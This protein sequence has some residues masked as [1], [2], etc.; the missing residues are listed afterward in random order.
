M[1]QELSPQAKDLLTQKKIK[2][3][4]IVWEILEHDGYDEMGPKSNLWDLFIMDPDSKSPQLVQHFHR[5]YWFDGQDN[6]PYLWE[7]E[8]TRDAILHL[9]NIQPMKQEK[10]L[11]GNKQ[12]HEKSIL[13]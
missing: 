9:G 12:N 6:E 11:I 10:N 5:E 8:T 1:K 13:F 2:D 3:S 4:C 7:Q